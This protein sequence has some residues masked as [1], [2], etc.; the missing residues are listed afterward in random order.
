MLRIAAARA[1]SAWRSSAPELA[2]LCGGNLLQHE[3]CSSSI[4]TGSLRHLS[5]LSW[6]SSI[7]KPAQPAQSSQAALALPDLDAPAAAP[8]FFPLP[9]ESI[10]AGIAIHQAIKASELGVL[11]A[12]KA[13]CFFTTAWMFEAVQQFHTS[14]GLPWQVGPAVCLHA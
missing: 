5:S 4:S 8:S 10:E 6:W 1:C 3:A 9:E 2:V 7:T 14:L 12:A 13:D 11:A